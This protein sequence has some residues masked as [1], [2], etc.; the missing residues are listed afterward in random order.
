MDPSSS[1]HVQL[2]RRLLFT[3]LDS[4]YPP[5]SK[6]RNTLILPC[7]RRPNSNG[8]FR[9][10][11]S[12]GDIAMG[13]FLP[14]HQ[15]LKKNGKSAPS[16]SQDETHDGITFFFL[17]MYM[18]CTEYPYAPVRSDKNRMYGKNH[19]L[20]GNNICKK[21]RTHAEFL[22]ALRLRLRLGHLFL[23]PRARRN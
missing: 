7:T 1:R 12:S 2:Q 8:Y 22:P 9:P 4:F 15:K 23:L 18:S 13:P 20:A 14:Q 16:P 5:K 6:E 10:S 21:A 3:I 17:R 19:H 11:G